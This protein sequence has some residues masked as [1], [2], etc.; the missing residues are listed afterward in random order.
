MSLV[1]F[2]PLPT[3]SSSVSSNVLLSLPS[4]LDVAD[5]VIRAELIMAIGLVVDYVIHI[6]H[7]ALHQVRTFAELLAFVVPC[8]GRFIARAWDLRESTAHLQ[9]SS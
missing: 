2:R 5:G 7:F 9:A 4:I 6:V 3:T 1:L 8:K